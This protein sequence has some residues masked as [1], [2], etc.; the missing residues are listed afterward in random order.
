[1]A[2]MWRR[3]PS[4]TRL[5]LVDD[6]AINHQESRSIENHNILFN[7]KRDVGIDLVE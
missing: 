1:M 5:R 4:K 3:L 2:K 7:M 6:Q